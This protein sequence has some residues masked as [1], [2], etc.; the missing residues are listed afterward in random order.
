[1]IFCKFLIFFMNYTVK[2]RINREKEEHERETVIEGEKRK[3]GTRG[4]QGVPPYRVRSQT[5]S[6]SDGPTKRPRP[7]PRPS[8]SLR[9]SREQCQT[10]E[11]KERC[12]KF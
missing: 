7:S 11:G 6:Y 10:S 4:N 8:K 5:V 3:T 12:S 9:L 2:A 1:M